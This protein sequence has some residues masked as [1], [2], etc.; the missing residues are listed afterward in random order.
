MFTP[1]IL[2]IIWKYE[3]STSLGSVQSSSGSNHVDIEK[4]VVKSQAGDT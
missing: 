2:I 3:S 1:G 4:K